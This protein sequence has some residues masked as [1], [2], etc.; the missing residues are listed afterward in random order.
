MSGTSFHVRPNALPSALAQLSPKTRK[1]LVEAAF[2][3]IRDAQ[4]PPAR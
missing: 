3:M 2:D 4:G 1:L